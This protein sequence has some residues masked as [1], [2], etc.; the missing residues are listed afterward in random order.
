MNKTDLY[1][2]LC[3]QAQQLARQA[4]LLDTEVKVKARLLSA[5]EALGDPGRTDFPLQKGKESL[6]QAEF[7]GS[8]GQA[9]TDQ[10]SSFS[11]SL[12][13]VLNLS[14]DNNRNR[15]LFVA[16]LNALMRHL[17]HAIGTVH[18]RDDG[19]RGCAGMLVEYLTARCGTPRVAFVGL[20][21]TLVEACAGRFPVRVVDLDPENIGRQRAGVMIE[22]GGGN[23]S[24]FREWAD[25]FLITGSTLVNGTISTWLDAPAPTIFYG[26][27]IAGAA[28]LLKL[29]R[30]CPY[31]T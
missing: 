7:L 12:R 10:P 30:F 29:E 3:W 23:L 1:T 24:D 11:G 13:E 27:T 20:Q 31:S 25:I 28:T 17:G 4:G 2:L 6:V 8:L 16:A 9:Y 22:D 5:R 19:P 14:L 15:A 26:T 18:C 21:P